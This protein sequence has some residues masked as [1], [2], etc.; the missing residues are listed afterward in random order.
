MTPLHLLASR[1]NVE[2]MALLLDKG[3]DPNARASDGAVPLHSAVL[4]SQP[5]AVRL[6]AGHG[7]NLESADVRGRTP[8]VAAA[9]EMKGTGVIATLLDLGARIDAADS[10]ADTALT[11]AAWRGSTDVVSLL[12]GRGASVP[13]NTDKGR[14]LFDRAVSNGLPDLFR[15]M[16]R[17]G[18]ELPAPGPEAALLHRAAAGGAVPIVATIVDRGFAINA[19][20]RNGWTP[21][22]FA[23]DL[24]RTE[25]ITFLLGRGADLNVRTLMGQSPFNI[26]Q[27]NADEATAA[28]LAGK[29]AD[30]GA[31]RFPELRGPYMGQKPPGR[32]PEPFAAGIVSARYG[33][34]STIVFSPDGTEAFWSV[35]VPPRKAGYGTGRTLVSRLVDGRWTYPRRA[36]FDGVPLDDSPSFHPDGQRLYDMSFR[37]LPDGEGSRS[38]HIWAWQ[39]GAAGWTRPQPLDPAVNRLPQ[40]WQFSVARDGTLYF[41]S[42]WAGA[43]GIF[44]TRLVN[45]AYTNPVPLEA[46]L[47]PDAQFPSVAP[48]GRYL[49]FVMEMNDI[50]VSFREAGGG[51]GR[52]VSLGDEYR[53][54]LPRVS[55]DGKYLFFLGFRGLYWVDASVIEQRRPAR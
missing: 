42:R 28:L 48:D 5:E 23:A 4:G 52:P 35:S 39:K 50:R 30:P 11:L 31:P 21:L 54:I 40:H 9:R 20:D 51:W 25:A 14:E 7:A 29:G 36:V 6:L 19:A 33:L 27:D 13:V 22:H 34:H 37:P 43:T 55:P 10:A 47:G 41:S 3:A 17:K 45:G 26:A 2:G 46:V 8:L 38:E 24:G 12:L 49:L 15:E 1:G 32:V 44:V 18:A 53:G 16:L